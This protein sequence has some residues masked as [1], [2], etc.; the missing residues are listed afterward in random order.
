MNL[1][2]G[3]TRQS[4]HR[5]RRNFGTTLC[6]P[7]HMPLTPYSCTR[8]E[9][10][11]YQPWAS[12]KG[13]GGIDLPL[14]G[15]IHPQTASDHRQEPFASERRV[16]TLGQ[17]GNTGS[18]GSGSIPTR[19]R[20]PPGPRVTRSVR[21]SSFCLSAS[22]HPSHSGPAGADWPVGFGSAAEAAPPTAAIG[23]VRGPGTAQIPDGGP[24]GEM[25]QQRSRRASG[26]PRWCAE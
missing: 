4:K 2:F 1:P 10:P 22:F 9:C 21:P 18:N 15:E 14:R 12:R 23:A 5:V 11:E 8:A 6:G 24:A 26:P 16:R 13:R 19:A 7:A 25:R 3:A 17:K 20:A